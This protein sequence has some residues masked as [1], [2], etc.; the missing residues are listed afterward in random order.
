MSIQFIWDKKKASANLQKHNISFE[1]A[2]S[3][4]YDD[5][6]RIVFDPDHSETEDRFIILGVSKE[7]NILVV[8]HCYKE[9]DSAIRLISARKATRNEKSQYKENL[10]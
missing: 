3:V 8:V 10:P 9:N 7:S 1:E 4:F 6:A 2:K 5:F